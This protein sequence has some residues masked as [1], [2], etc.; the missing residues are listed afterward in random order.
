MPKKIKDSEDRLKTIEFLLAGILLGK[1][2]K[3]QEVA[4]IL[5]CHNSVLTKMYPERKV[6]KN[7]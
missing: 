2:P 3:V 1:K 4:R 5:G 6:K 7:E